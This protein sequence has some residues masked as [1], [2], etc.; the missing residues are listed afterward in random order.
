MLQYAASGNQ[1]FA[2]KQ[3]RLSPALHLPATD[4]LSQGSEE[5]LG[6]L[7]GDRATS[8]RLLA[9]EHPIQE[10]LLKIPLKVGSL[11]FGVLNP[12]A[13]PSP[14]GLS[15]SPLPP[16]FP[17]QGCVYSLDAGRRGH[18]WQLKYSRQRGTSRQR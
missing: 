10:V 9:Q 12:V 15:V 18:A 14:V 6:P 3:S 13:A 7:L 8:G 16:S 5:T 4:R 17:P 11:V 2:I 1:T